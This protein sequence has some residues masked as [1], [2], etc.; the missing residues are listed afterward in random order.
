MVFIA[1][2]PGHD[3]SVIASASSIGSGE[4]AHVFSLIISLW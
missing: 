2:G 3:I 4:S 1:H